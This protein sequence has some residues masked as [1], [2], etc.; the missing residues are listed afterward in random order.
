MDLCQDYEL[1]FPLRGPGKP[2]GQKFLKDG[3]EFQNFPPRSD[4]PKKWKSYSKITE[5]VVSEYFFL[6][7]GGNFRHF[8]G[9]D[10]GRDIY[11]RNMFLLLLL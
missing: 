6:F 8:R 9:W 11:I 4:P 3:E 1:F 5:I 2:P 10:R 7:F